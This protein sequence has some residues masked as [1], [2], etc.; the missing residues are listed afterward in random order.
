MRVRCWSPFC[1]W[2]G[3]QSQSNIKDKWGQFNV[4][5]F[6]MIAHSPLT[7]DIFLLHRTWLSP[8]NPSKPWGATKLSESSTT[9]R[10]VCVCFWLSYQNKNFSR[11]HHHAW[12]VRI[13]FYGG[14]HLLCKLWQVIGK[15]IYLKV[16]NINQIQF[17]YIE[18]ITIKCLL[19][20]FFKGK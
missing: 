3:G 16:R 10:C 4:V 14:W 18:Q 13:L 6:V 1:L 12:F 20:A 2:K 11:F 19:K 7:S 15:K 5:S 8:G 9:Q 17:A